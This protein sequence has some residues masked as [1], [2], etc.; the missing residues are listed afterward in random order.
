MAD[1]TPPTSI[2]VGM[3]N[4]KP[5]HAALKAWYA[6]SNDR[7]EV[8]VDGSI[9][10]IVRGELLVEIQ[11]R[12]FSPLK[13]KLEKLTADHPVRLV[14]P[15]AAEKW[16]VRLSGDGAVPERRRKSPKR[17]S[18]FEL[19]RELVSFPHLIS[20]PNFSL[21]VLLIQEEE[22]R[23]QDLSRNWRRRGW[24]TVERRLVQV[25]DRRLFAT[26]ADL[27]ALLPP[28]LAE[29]FTTAGLADA[30]DE[31]RWLAQKMVYCLRSMGAIAEAGRLG[32][33]TRYV[34]I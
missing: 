1:E 29:P 3:L 13:R 18:V 31:P 15:I 6:G 34:R 28:T 17:G 5:L 30:I 8:K 11:T 20:H 23:Q 25:V 21:E 16:I 22:V 12:S 32:K 27:V 14:Y 7:F 33:A 9:I 24:G 2:G 4:E 26:P 19:F 10:D